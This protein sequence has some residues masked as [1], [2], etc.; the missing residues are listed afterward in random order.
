MD[1]LKT[2]LIYMTMVYV[3][4]VQAAPEPSPTPLVP[5]ATPTALVAQE[6][7]T[8][9]PTNTPV[10]TPT[11]TPVPTPNITPNTAY[12]TIQ[13]GDK[14][15]KVKELQ[16]R[17]AELG[18]YTGNIDG[19]FGNQTRRAVE[20]F[21]YNQGLS[22]DGIAGKRTL[23][24]LYESS[25]VR[26]APTEGTPSP[27]PSATPSGGPTAAITQAPN[28]PV[29]TFVPTETPSVSPTPAKTAAV[30]ATP[31]ATPAARA[32]KPSAAKALDTLALTLDGQTEPMKAQEA[33]GG[34]ELHP[35]EWDG[36]VYVPYIAMLQSV[37][38]VILP[39]T[40]A[41]AQELAF[42]QGKDVFRLTYTLDDDGNAASLVIYKNEKQQ[43]VSPRRAMVRDG[44]LYLPLTV[45]ESVF[46]T[47][48]AQT[49]EGYA[50]SFAAEA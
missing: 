38:T 39:G 32:S 18:Y 27:T 40:S 15:D 11:P 6:Q 26:P 14:G 21:Q 5:V 2:I 36:D 25:D 47:T 34:A 8:P 4:A 45:T 28:T 29:P 41:D 9:A 10:P 35:L 7:P 46:G 42:A 22:A 44:L 24:V 13:T 1:L 43:I 37:G 23:T 20:R 49:D 48:Y 17:L 30:T 12:K 16:T 33:D 31:T 19:A 3:S 50:V